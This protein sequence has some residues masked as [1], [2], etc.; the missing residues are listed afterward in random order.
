MAKA[1][2][3]F[4]PSLESADAVECIYC[5]VELDGWEPKDDPLVEHERRANGL[6]CAFFVGLTQHG[7]ASSIFAR[8]K[9]AFA[10]E[11]ALQKS[12]ETQSDNSQVSRH[13]ASPNLILPDL[14]AVAELKTGDKKRSVRRKLP[15]ARSKRTL[16]VEDS[17]DEETEAKQPIPIVLKSA[18]KKRTS[19]QMIEDSPMLETSETTPI[20]K[21]GRRTR[22]MSV[23]GRTDYTETAHSPEVAKPKRSSSR[24]RGRRARTPLEDV[25]ESTYNTEVD[26]GSG[27]V[28][29]IKEEE[30]DETHAF[31]SYPLVKAG[32]RL[33][34]KDH[35]KE[36]LEKE[37]KNQRVRSSTT[38][39]RT[40]GKKNPAGL[41]TRAVQE[42]EQAD[43]SKSLPAEKE[44]SDLARILDDTIEE[45]VEGLVSGEP[46]E[47]VPSEK[48]NGAGASIP[49]GSPV[50]YRNS[51][52]A[53]SVPTPITFETT[54]PNGP[55][56]KQKR[57]SRVSR[58]L[59]RSG[60]GP[61]ANT[62]NA[63]DVALEGSISTFPKARRTSSR[64]GSAA[65]TIPGIEVII[66]SSARSASIGGSQRR[67]S[68]RRRGSRSAISENVEDVVMLDHK[69]RPKVQR[70]ARKGHVTAPA[71]VVDNPS[72][73][74]IREEPEELVEHAIPAIPI[75][76]DKPVSEAC[77]FGS[78]D[79]APISLAI[80]T[81]AE[82][83]P[84]VLNA[85]PVS[86]LK[87]MPDA[88]AVLI[89]A[90]FADIE[91]ASP[92]DTP[93][94]T[95]HEPENTNSTQEEEEEEEEEDS[96]NTPWRTYFDDLYDGTER[97]VAT[98]EKGSIL[99]LAAQ[100]GELTLE[101]WMR[102]KVVEQSAL[103][104]TRC[105]SMIARLEQEGLKVR[106][107]IESA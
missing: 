63:E 33:H 78:E 88:E 36:N 87:Q 62:P 58:N 49:A 75:V 83:V 82:E 52:R 32:I 107:S 95:L 4:A 74:S 13:G 37:K 6:D 42:S 47:Q 85:S 35:N 21:R 89:E 1:G 8:T 20:K 77:Y 31:P 3:H 81:I 60:S 22:S 71:F 2:F 39:N 45:V 99:S 26:L 67:T 70:T 103:L 56:V 105:E 79:T 86:S 53:E 44:A 27:I 46:L 73:E 43:G 69:A 100:H 64:R 25:G 55:H 96:S 29:T 98:Q 14:P 61:P 59:V 7:A 97:H 90:A 76:N 15:P 92:S 28:Q 9:D 50:N 5:R 93:V 101:Q 40:T 48:E 23:G 102:W 11:R 104:K 18:R 106:S 38:S 54:E 91:G 41:A 12:V 34:N 30:E 24:P 66:S 68:S 19:D 16:M 65:A 17:T 80:D 57:T 51:L 84:I 72:S 10:A 94:T